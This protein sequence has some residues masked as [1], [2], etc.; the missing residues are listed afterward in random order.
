MKPLKQRLR[1]KGL[2]AMGT[3]KGL[4]VTPVKLRAVLRR[5]KPPATKR[6]TR[7][8]LMAQHVAETGKPNSGR[9]WNRLKRQLRREDRGANG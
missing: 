6:D 4:K 7:R 1:D 8:E 3:F 9:Q 2:K 5:P